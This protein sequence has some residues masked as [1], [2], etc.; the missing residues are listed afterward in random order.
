MKMIDD[1]RLRG[2]ALLAPWQAIANDWLEK[3]LL[4]H[5]RQLASREQRMV[6]I[7]M[8][9]LPLML[10]VF[11]IALPLKDKLIASK[12]ELIIAQQEAAEAQYLAKHVGQNRNGDKDSQPV[13]LLES[14]EKLARQ[15]HL[16]E[17]MTSIRPLPVVSGSQRL[18]FELKDAPYE[19]VMRFSHALTQEDL[20]LISMKIQLGSS[21]GLVHV[22]A[23]ID[24]K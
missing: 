8:I 15:L 22:Q 3:E 2:L 24:G 11:G 10:V 7:A 6:L 17:F 14:V 20:E 13:N 21:A 18:M 9:L 4:P 1:I 12:A 19:Q 23:I 16:R 5:Y